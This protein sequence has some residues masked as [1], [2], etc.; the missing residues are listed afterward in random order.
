MVKKKVKIIIFFLVFNIGLFLL[1]AR[2]NT[3]LRFKEYAGVQDRFADM[4]KDSI[5]LV[6]IGSSHQFCSISA[7]HLYE[8][9]GV[10][11]FMLATSAQTIPMSYYAAM[12]A[13][14]LQHPDT[15]CLEL[16]YVAN[17][18][19][20]VTDEMSHCF[21][22]GM[23]RCEARKLALQDLIEPGEQINY[24]LL[25]GLYHNR[26]KELTEKDYGEVSVSKRGDFFSKDVL[27]NSEIPLVGQNETEPMD[28][29][30]KKYLDLLVELC[31]ENDVKLVFY[32]APY[33]TLWD[34][35]E[36]TADLLC[37]Q[38]IFNGIGEYAAEK[39]VA[40]YNLFYRLPEL[41]LDFSND[42]RDRQHLN[43]Y[44]QQKLTDYMM[45]KGCFK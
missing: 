17:G 22:D 30:M 14:E 34:G 16:C 41:G 25:L 15:I 26:W 37:S 32:V 1:I 38:R 7:E 21:F 23:P 28:E 39:G 2:A 35:E 4:P 10:E 31:R 44:G 20:T 24:E 42:W 8:E 45:S 13:I 18:F 27:A 3:V 40:F 11:A 43:C 9:Y 36:P 19:R 29:E 33:N 5:D 6:F 12:E